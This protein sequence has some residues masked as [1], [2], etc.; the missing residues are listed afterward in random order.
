MRHEHELQVCI[1]L[2]EYAIFSDTRRL[3]ELSYNWAYAVQT[4]FSNDDFFDR[5]WKKVHKTVREV[6]SDYHDGESVQYLYAPAA[7]VR[8]RLKLQGYTH[9][10][11]LA[12]WEAEKAK[13]VSS[14]E[15]IVSERDADLRD[16]IDRLRDLTFEK[17][18]AEMDDLDVQGALKWG[19]VHLLSFSDEIA[20][21][22]LFIDVRSP[23]AIWTDLSSF[24]AEDF[25]PELTLHENLSRE[26]AEIGYSF[27]EPVGNVL[28]L[29]EGPSDTRI[30]SAAIKAMYPEYS[31]MF[32]FVDFREFKIEGGASPLTKMVRTFA[33]IRMKERV[34]ALFDNDAAGHEQIRLLE[35]AK[36]PKNI[37][38]ITLPDLPFA[39]KYPTIGPEGLREMNVNGA[40]CAIEMYL[41]KSALLDEKGNLRPVRWTNWSQNA[42]RYQGALEGKDVV[43]RHFLEVMAAGGAPGELRRRFKDM[44]RLLKAIFCAFG[45]V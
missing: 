9:E 32:S 13:H 28:I 15:N 21:L 39:K 20:E 18:H 31:D 27:I 25:D 14:L 19:G 29:T 43:A 26:P 37:K 24:Y 41:G 22:A 38:A 35:K 6:L 12:L 17:W 5:P 40:A 33:G 45:P 16:E 34:L 30:L 36:L 44:D 8:A 7:K 10:K 11:C 23:K 42:G 3:L 4:I 1:K 2:S